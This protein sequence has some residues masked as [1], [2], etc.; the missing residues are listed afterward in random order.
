MGIDDI[1]MI[2]EPLLTEDGFINPACM[3]ALEAAI[4]N[5]PKTYDQLS[6]E[7]EWNIPRWTHYREITA[8]LAYCAVKQFLDDYPD[9]EDNT[10]YEP[11]PP[12]HA[13]NLEKIIGFLHACIRPKFDKNGSAFLSL[14]DISK[15]LYDILYG[16]GVSVFDDWNKKEVMAMHW[17]DLDALLHNVCLLIRQDRRE[18]DRFNERFHKE[19]ANCKIKKFGTDQTAH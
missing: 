9:D 2:D 3:N 7:P 8:G 16:Q 1:E 14:C 4:K 13:P 5:M 12:A 18:F 6:D 15:M 17:I 19:Q 10:I 11:K